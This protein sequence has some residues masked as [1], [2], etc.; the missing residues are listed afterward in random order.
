MVVTRKT[1]ASSL[2]NAFSSTNVDVQYQ[3]ILYGMLQ[4]FL[5][6]NWT[7]EASSN[8]TT[9]DTGNQISSASDIIVAA[10]GV[11]HTWFS[12]VPPTGK[13]NPTGGVQFRVL[14]DCVDASAPLTSVSIYLA[15]GS[16]DPA[17]VTTSKP[18]ITGTE[19]TA[20]SIAIIPWTAAAG[21]YSVWYTTDGDIYLGGKLDA[22]DAFRSFFTIND[23]PYSALGNWTMRIFAATNATDAVTLTAL[24]GS[25]SWRNLTQAGASNSVARCAGRSTNTDL[26]T[27]TSGEEDST[28]FVR[29]EPIAT[30][31]NHSTFSRD[32]GFLVDVVSVPPQTPFNLTDVNDSAAMRLL[33]I[34]DIMLPTTFSQVPILGGSASTDTLYNSWASAQVTPAVITS[35]LTIIN[36]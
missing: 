19:D 20:I 15:T 1:W 10:D 25:S 32:L 35:G 17:Y 21:R 16:Y 26:S 23:D 18:S 33:G 27:W 29:T 28:G 30:T 9:A 34:G 7:V 13:G 5:S 3:E 12:L 24:G 2:N 14:F 31:T 22:D 8:G 4:A 6:G 36:S 11:A